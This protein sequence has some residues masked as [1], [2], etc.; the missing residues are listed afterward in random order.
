[1]KKR[2][3][4]F[5]LA[6]V[7]AVSLLPVQVFAEVVENMATPE[8]T[9]VVEPRVQTTEEAKDENGNTQ[10]GISTFATDAWN[11]T[12]STDAGEVISVV[13]DEGGESCTIVVPEAAKSLLVK[14]ERIAYIVNSGY[15]SAVT[16]D[17]WGAEND[18]GVDKWEAL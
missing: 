11:V 6:L 16:T 12:F 9:I 3:V 1:M 17:D 8:E 15:D 5:L 4:S 18:V 10:A 7:M 13:Y 2:I 14:A